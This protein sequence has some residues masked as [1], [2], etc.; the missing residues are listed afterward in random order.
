MLLL[1]KPLRKNT[2]KLDS[3]KK[4]L[5]NLAMKDYC[6]KAWERQEKFSRLL[7][8]GRVYRVMANT[9]MLSK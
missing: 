5:S 9:C 7:W 8:R 6:D 4:M 1:S 3:Y 2:D